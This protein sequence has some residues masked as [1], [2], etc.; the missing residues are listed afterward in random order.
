MS[1]AMA[2]KQLIGQIGV[3]SDNNENCALDMAKSYLHYGKVNSA[4]EI[5]ARIESV[6]VDDVLM[7]ANDRLDE[8]RLSLLAYDPG[9]QV[10][11][12]L[13]AVQASRPA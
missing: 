13:R 5:F 8:G 7:V 10:T 2:K 9:G 11:A 3:A 1:L 4:E 12:R 6:S